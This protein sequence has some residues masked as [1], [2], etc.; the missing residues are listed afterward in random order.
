MPRGKRD[1]LNIEARRR[2]V[3]ELRR[4]GLSLRAIGDILNVDHSTVAKDLQAMLKQLAKDNADKAEEQRALDLDRIDKALEVV[5]AAVASNDVG[6]VN[7]LDKLL[8][9]RAKLLG[10]DAPTRQ[11]VSGPDG[12]AI[13]V[14]VQARNYRDAINAL[15][16]DD[17]ESA[18]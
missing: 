3:L 14:G 13:E 9:R 1:E 18:Q 12:G 15:K 8:T 4:D 10:L 2:Q 11:E 5:M 7:A 16:P 17:D 6:A